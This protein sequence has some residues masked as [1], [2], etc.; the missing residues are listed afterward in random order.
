MVFGRSYGIQGSLKFVI[1]YRS[2]Q[3]INIILETA[4]CR[5]VWQFARVYLRNF[6]LCMLELHET[7][8]DCYSGC[9]ARNLLASDFAEY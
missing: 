7:S 2:A 9:T 5:K 4:Y 8:T 1:H 3:F 6:C